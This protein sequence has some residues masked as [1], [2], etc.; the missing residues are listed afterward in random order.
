VERESE[1]ERKGGVGGGVRET[2]REEESDK[3]AQKKGGRREERK[4]K[5]KSWGISLWVVKRS[6]RQRKGGDER[7]LVNYRWFRVRR[8]G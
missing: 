7:P 1:R 4:R 5:R 2:R 6:C 8:E 3:R